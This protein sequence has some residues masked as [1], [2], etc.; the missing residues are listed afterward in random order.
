MNYIRHDDIHAKRDDRNTSKIN[1]KKL[2]D[3]ILNNSLLVC[4]YHKKTINPLC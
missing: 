3:N 1:N 2:D 4:S